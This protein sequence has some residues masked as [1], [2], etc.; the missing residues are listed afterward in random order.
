MV[1]AQTN[2]V[3]CFLCVPGVLRPPRALVNKNLGDVAI[4]ISHGY[5]DASVALRALDDAWRNVAGA[6]T[7]ELHVAECKWIP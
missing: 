4:D 2:E 1:P 6:N 3:S 7:S 5:A